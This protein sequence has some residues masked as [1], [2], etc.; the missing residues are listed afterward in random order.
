MDE[1]EQWKEHQEAM[2]ILIEDIMNPIII[3][4]ILVTFF[5]DSKRIF[6]FE[7]EEDQLHYIEQLKEDV[8]KLSIKDITFFESL[9]NYTAED[10]EQMFTMHQGGL[11]EE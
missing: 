5:D 2:D 6:T 3:Y 9:L 1:Y 10:V 4:S 7:H 11:Y 8:D